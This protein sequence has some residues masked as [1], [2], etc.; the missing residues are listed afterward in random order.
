M[1]RISVKAKSAREYAKKRW[2]AFAWLHLA[3][4]DMREEFK[5]TLIKCHDYDREV[6]RLR[7]ICDDIE[8]RSEF[9]QESAEKWEEAYRLMEMAY[10]KLVDEV[11]FR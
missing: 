7:L 9:W 4:D 6:Q 1:N 8:T 2:E 11:A 10:N 3:P 5:R